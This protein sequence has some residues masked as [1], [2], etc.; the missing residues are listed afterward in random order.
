MTMRIPLLAGRDF[1]ESDDAK[2]A[3]VL[4]VNQAFARRYFHSETRGGPPGAHIRQMDDR[5]G[6]GP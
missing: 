4:I 3:P 5:G 1:K 2:A 6:P